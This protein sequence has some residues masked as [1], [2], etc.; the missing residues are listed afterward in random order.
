MQLRMSRMG[1]QC[2][3]SSHDRALACR[4]PPS[5]DVMALTYMEYRRSERFGKIP[6]EKYLQEIGFTDPA[7]DV[8]GMDDAAQFVATPGGP[9][10][11]AL[12]AQPVLG[13]VQIKVLL[14]DFP[15][16]PGLLPPEHY[17]DLLFSS[18]IYPTGSIRDYYDEVSLGKVDVIG[19]VDGWLRMPEPYA[20]YTNGES[21]TKWGSYPNNAPRLAED[22]VN[23]ALA[24][25]VRFDPSLDKFGRGII[26]ALFIVHAGRG[27]EVMPPALRGGE[28][29][30][31][32]WNFRNPV[33]VAPNLAATLYLTVPFDCKVGVCAHELGHLAFQWQDFYDPNYEKDGQWDGSGL[34]DLMAGGSY[35][36]DSARPAHPAPLHKLQHGWIDVTTIRASTD[37]KIKPYSATSGHV[38]KLVSPNYSPKQYLLLES[39]KKV[40]FDFH[41]P[42]E[43]L[44]VWR[45]DE[46]GEMN[47]AAKSGMMLV[48]ADG[49]HNLEDPND[50]NNQGDAGD[51]FPGE[52]NQTFLDDEGAISTSFEGARSGISLK[53]IQFSSDGVVS[54]KVA[55]KKFA[56]AK[57]EAPPLP[58]SGAKK[59]AKGA[60]KED[61]KPTKRAT[62]KSPRKATKKGTKSTARVKGRSSSRA[63]S[64][65]RPTTR[66]VP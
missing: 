59:G 15:D 19:T 34:W 65:R 3:C 38:Y 27:A 64:N 14:V 12:P 22:A 53:N 4:V 39:R 49:K 16:R 52:E 61:R 10:L 2:R 7:V 57:K 11:L 35:N 51:P 25:G 50:W 41:L 37:L 33:E 40:G 17:K 26:T 23:A 30:S 5:P 43:G 31:H 58:P 1:W 28:I 32:K 62:K 21:G 42:G 44:L 20:Y 56:T 9:E 6:F 18:K 8:V 48:Q 63:K 45:V 55:F 29:W 36:G 13:E 66:S 24:K 60:A 47:A 54:L 46:V